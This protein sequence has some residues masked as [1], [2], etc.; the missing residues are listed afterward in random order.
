MILNEHGNVYFFFY[1][2]VTNYHKYKGLRQHVF[3]THR[4]RGSRVWAYLAGFSAQC[5]PRLQ[6]RLAVS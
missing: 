3:T 5:L 6:F 2:C 1:Y 4:V